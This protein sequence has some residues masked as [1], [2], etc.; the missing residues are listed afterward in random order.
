M[1]NL[2]QRLNVEHNSEIIEEIT[3][4]SVITTYIGSGA[5]GSNTANQYAAST[6][7][8]QKVVATTDGGTVTT[9]IAFPNWDNRYSFCWD[10]RA[11]Y[12]YS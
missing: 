9:T 7:Q 11:S 12:S 6:W 3:D 5:P 2:S 1:Y 10:D 8:I 4:G